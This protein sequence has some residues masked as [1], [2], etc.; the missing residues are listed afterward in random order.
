MSNVIELNNTANH[1]KRRMDHHGVPA[2]TQGVLIRYIEN[3]YD[4]G[5]FLTAVLSNDLFG[6]IWR[7]DPENLRAL[8]GICQFIYSDM[9]SSAWG[10]PD[11]VAAWLDR[12]A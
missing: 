12:R 10:T 6:A 2:H 8:E 4:P 7:A 3:R 11:N 9:P 1:W 5:S